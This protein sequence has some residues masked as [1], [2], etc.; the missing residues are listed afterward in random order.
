MTCADDVAAML[1]CGVTDSW[2]LDKTIHVKITRTGWQKTK[3]G[4]ND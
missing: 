1:K 4:D 3:V 2:T